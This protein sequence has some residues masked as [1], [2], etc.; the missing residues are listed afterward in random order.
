MLEFTDSREGV[1]RAGVR[2]SQ[3]QGCFAIDL[4]L[5]EVTDE[6]HC[7]LL[8]AFQFSVMGSGAGGTT[9]SCVL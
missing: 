3:S 7:G 9:A 5:E 1:N 8:S 2:G 6:Q 4:K